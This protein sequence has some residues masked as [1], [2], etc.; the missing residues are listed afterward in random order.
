MHISHFMVSFLR[1]KML[2][3][4]N[5]QPQSLI[6]SECLPHNST[7]VEGTLSR[8][9]R[10]VDVGEAKK[11]FRENRVDRMEAINSFIVSKTFFSNQTIHSKKY[12]RRKE[13]HLVDKASNAQTALRILPKGWITESLSREISSE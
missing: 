12:F 13:K 11:I 8:N 7:D 10:D 1:Q 9:V 2:N 3:G 5:G 6:I 4:E